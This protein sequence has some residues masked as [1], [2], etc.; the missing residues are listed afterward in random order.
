MTELRRNLVTHGSSYR[1]ATSLFSDHVPGGF[2]VLLA[3]AFDEAVLRQKMDF[4]RDIPG[5]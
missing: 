1:H 2:V 3:D 4:V 5:F